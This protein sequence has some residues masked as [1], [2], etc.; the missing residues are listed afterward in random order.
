VPFETVTPHHLRPAR[1]GFVNRA[2]E[3]E[4]LE[5]AVANHAQSSRILVLE[6]PSGAG[7]SR[8]AEEWAQRRKSSYPDGQLLID[9]RSLRASPAGSVA[10]ALRS[11]LLAF[12][13]P[14]KK[15]PET[16][17]DRVGLYRTLTAERRLLLVLDHVTEA[18]EVYAL[19]PDAPEALLLVTTNS[20][21]AAL[22]QYGAISVPVDILDAVHSRSMLHALA[23]RPPSGEAESRACDTVLAYC[24]GL[25][26]ALD[27]C[28]KRIRDEG[29]GS[30][31]WL[32]DELEHEET[33]LQRMGVPSKSLDIVFGATYLALSADHARAYRLLGQAPRLSS[34]SQV[35]AVLGVGEHAATSILSALRSRHLVEVNTSEVAGQPERTDMVCTTCYAFTREQLRSPTAQRARN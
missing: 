17:H 27:L 19:L 23:G 18:G 3:L 22:R 35:A 34:L 8:L 14:A 32:A 15:I 9:F 1:L 10:E 12:G 2:A 4:L 29:L 33:R 24:A 11:I 6:G 30:Y 26:L 28:A 5:G 7:K 21:M 20:D 25:P 16:L 31:A 13:C